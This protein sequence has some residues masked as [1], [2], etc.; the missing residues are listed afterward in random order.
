MSNDSSDRR[1]DLRARHFIPLA[2]FALPTIAIGYG[3]VIPGSCIAGLN[4]LT[5]GFASAIAG[6]C[7]TYWI[8]LRALARES[9]TRR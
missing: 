3:F 2:G 9:E 6:A 1:R 4:E 7:V 8:G 5:V